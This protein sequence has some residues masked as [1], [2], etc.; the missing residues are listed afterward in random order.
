MES[1]PDNNPSIL[2]VDDEVPV[3]LAIKSMLVES[4]LPEPALVSDSRRVMDVVR[5]GNFQVVLLDILMPHESGITVLGQLKNEFP[6]I[7]CVVVT[8]VDEVTCAVSVMKLGAYE[9]LVKPFTCEK[10]VIVIKSALDR[11]KIRNRL[12][13][14][15]QS[16]SL[17]DLRNPEAFNEMIAKAETMA[18]V[19]HQAE[20]AATTDYNVIITGESG[21]GKEMLAKIIHG[22]SHRAA[23]PFVAVNMASFNRNLFEDDFFGHRRGAYTGAWSERRG[24]FEAAEEGTLFL[25][26]IVDL[27]LPLQSKL[28]RVI[29]DKEYYRLGS[30]EAKT[31]DVRIISATNRDIVKEVKEGTFRTDLFYRLNTCNIHIPPLRERKDDILPLAR[32]FLKKHVQ[33]TKKNITSLAPEVKKWLVAYP[34]PGN[35]RELESI[36]ARAVLLERGDVLRISAVREFL[37][38]S[39]AVASTKSTL[40]SLAEMEKQHIHRVLEATGGNRTKAAGI[41]GIGL[42]TLQRKLKIFFAPDIAPE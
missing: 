34:Y 36:I 33:K 7:E 11:Y 22:L 41:L 26:E 25:D 29:E 30:T 37:S 13:A 32:F 16:P 15:E 9:Y 1:M 31:I 14:F 3:L 5:S 6:A 35:V 8:G 2:V 42:R 17:S 10:L 19:F 12:T 21:T 24:L 4:G 28:L 27:E 18:F 38:P 20:I 39:E 23:S 40:P